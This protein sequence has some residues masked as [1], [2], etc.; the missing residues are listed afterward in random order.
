MSKART[1]TANLL[2]IRPGDGLP[3][4][5]LLLHAFFK[6]SSVVFFETP[7]D[8]LFLKTCGVHWLPYVFVGTAIVASTIGFG[9]TK[10]ESRLSARKLLPL[11]LIT[12]SGATGLVYLALWISK[13]RWLVALVMIWRDV[14]WTLVTMEFWA[15]AG[16]LFNVRQGKRLFGLIASGDIL[17]RILCGA[18]IPVI[19]RWVG[20]LNLLLA[21]AASLV[22]GLGVLLYTIR[23]FP[24]RFS[25]GQ[26]E[27]GETEGV[28]EARPLSA[29]FR[30]RYLLLFFAISAAAIVVSYFIDYAF[31]DQSEGAFK[32]ANRLASFF[33]VFFAVTAFAQFLSSVALSGR[34]LTRYGLGVG[35]LLLP[36]VLIAT[37][38]SSIVA[39]HLQAAAVLLWLT[40]GTKLLEVVFTESIQTPAFRILYQPLRP[41]NRLRVQAV[42]ESIL[43]PIGLGI[44]GVFLILFSAV[45]AVKTIH[46]LY[47]AM[48]LLALWVPLGILLRRDYTT[49]LMSAL[50][51]KSFAGTS[52]SL[53][54]EGSI[55]VLKR[56]LKD[57]HPDVAVYCLKTLEESEHSSLEACLIDALEHPHAGVRQ[58]A[59]TRIEHL[60]APGALAAV[61]RCL[62]TEA[63]PEVCSAAVRAA[64]A[65]AESDAI[66]PVARYLEDENLEVR[67]AAVAGL[68]R[69]AGIDGVFVAGWRLSSWMNSPDAADRKAAARVLGETG[70]PTFY[71]PLLSLLCDRDMAVRRAALAAAGKLVN[72]RLI[73]LL[74]TNLTSPEVRDHA[75]E[76]LVRFGEAVIPD[77]EKVW[78]QPDCSRPLR[79]RLAH[80]CGR[81]GGPKGIEMLL[82]HIDSRDRYTRNRVLSSLVLCRYRAAAEQAGRI[83]DRI[84]KEAEAVTWALAALADLGC[85]EP[86][87]PLSS[88]LSQEVKAAQERVLYLLSFLYPASA[89]LQAKNGLES[90]ASEK[91]AEA[92]E[93]I[94][95]LVSADLKQVVCSL[96]DDVSAEDRLR[97]L[98]A[99]F[100]QQAMGR[101]ARLTEII[102][103]SPSVSTFWI[104]TCALFAAGKAGATECCHA[105]E[106]A[107]PHPDPLVRETAAW[108]LS[109]T[110]PN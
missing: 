77:L 107:L 50:G 14:Q 80:V 46:V 93:M 96:L 38:G 55:E 36:I 44:A 88:A 64:C 103:Q 20:T 47:F 101:N 68:L 27:E 18:S 6:G 37:V 8:T 63:S 82:K 30:N 56:R 62:Q 78:G 92:L 106:A 7:V 75:A 51:R 69:Y 108:A 34:L 3:L 16:L 87:R 11:L 19:V 40:I 32:D 70:I 84:L 74:L 24:A 10:L 86:V 109:V 72:P 2:G 43:E 60:A 98:G 58:Y 61:W 35:L 66:E 90:E 76:A 15:V 45:L 9:C 105:L 104:K 28:Q 5:L 71:R 102:T 48:G 97:T 81:V 31:Y 91:R 65:I 29:L 95:N 54:D 39:G 100:P 21:A 94:D 110:R 25:G 26:Q 49:Q 33:G 52:L 83:K 67:M 1:A 22:A 4:V 13:A 53:E 73:P 42:R 41:E 17:A 59:L 85:E 79:L 12:L 89:I 23:L 99:R 57:P